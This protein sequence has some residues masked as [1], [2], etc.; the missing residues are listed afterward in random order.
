MSKS[1]G[2]YHQFWT[3]SENAVNIT[4]YKRLTSNSSLTIFNLRLGRSQL[5][6]QWF[7]QLKMF[8][9]QI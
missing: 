8:N 7:K 2:D 9:G 5:M 1:G 3:A 4:K 6:M